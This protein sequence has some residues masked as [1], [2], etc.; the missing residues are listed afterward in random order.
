VINPLIIAVQL[1]LSRSKIIFFMAIVEQTLTL[2]MLGSGLPIDQAEHIARF[3][4]TGLSAQK[5]SDY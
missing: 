3:K 5:K 1:Q 4:R 2:I